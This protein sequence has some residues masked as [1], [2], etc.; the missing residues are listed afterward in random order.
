MLT[1][2][3]VE[4]PELLRRDANN[5]LDRLVRHPAASRWC[6]RPCGA[7]LNHRWASSRGRPRHRRGAAAAAATDRRLALCSFDML[8][9]GARSL[10]LASSPPL[11]RPMR[12]RSGRRSRRRRLSRQGR[13]PAPGPQPG[14]TAAAHRGVDQALRAQAA[15]LPRAPSD[16]ADGWCRALETGAAGRRPR[17]RPDDRCRGRPARD[18]IAR[19]WVALAQDSAT[20]DKPGLGLA[21]M[22]QSPCASGARLGR[23]D[24]RRTQDA[25]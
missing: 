25:R 8:G 1:G 19:C 11:Q 23:A 12:P 5:W 16:Y 6:G 13:I 14:G 3:L 21:A 24:S 17:P 18:R 15:L 22:G 20:R 10:A 2:R 9:E 4:L 7:W